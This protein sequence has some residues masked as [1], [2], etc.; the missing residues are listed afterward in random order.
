MTAAEA[1]AATPRHVAGAFAPP[2]AY[3]ADVLILALDRADETIA[4]IASALAQTGLRRH[5]VVLDQGSSPENLARLAAAVGGRGDATL[6]RLDRNF[7]V[8]GGRNRAAA[9]G[10]GR[11]MAVLDND[12][13]FADS[14]T[15]ARAVALLD[16][17]PTLAAI[18]M[19]IVVHDTGADD[20][21]A[22]G[23]P[24][25][26]LARTNGVF[27]AATFVGA[28]H[29]IRRAAWNDAGGYDEALFFCWEE[30][31]FCLRAI[32][33]GWRVQYRGD[34][35]VRHKVAAERR[36]GW[37]SAR[38]FYFVR[39]RIYIERKCGASWRAIAP[40]Y[41]AYLLRGARNGLLGP[42]VR[43]L[44][45]SVA[46]SSKMRRT[47]LTPQARAYLRAT[48]TVHRGALPTRIKSEVLRRLP[49]AA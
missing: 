30:F 42:T 13:E 16:A 35:I 3:D 19:R 34:M 11:A 48:D 43:A 4:A 39:N 20:L 40:R 22:W 38:W 12:A 37:S 7:G 46:L 23:Y 44:P 6:L 9:F 5:V 36:V 25:G 17:D 28:G 45:A 24:N 2:P 26:L 41:A 33:R 31:D 27:D 14:G 15:L 8:A 1:L 47:R 10:R 32:V 49:G 21:G 29:A 18:G